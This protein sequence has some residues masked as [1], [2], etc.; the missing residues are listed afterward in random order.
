MILTILIILG[1]AFYIMTPDER[2]RA[3]HGGVE[4]V[5]KALEITQRHYR[6]R[7]AFR[8]ALGDRTPRVLVTPAFGLLNVLVFVLMMTSAG[9]VGS[10]ETLAAWGGNLGLQTTNG[11]WWRLVTNVFLHRGLFHLVVN[12]IGLVQ[13]GLVLERLVGRLAFAGVYLAGGSLASLVS[14]SS[15]PVDVSVGAS[16]AIFGLYGMFAVLLGRGWM[17]PSALSI[18][19][20][21]L[22]WLAPGATIFVL[23]N[24]VGG[25]L[26]GNQ[27]VGIFVGAVGGF[28]LVGGA[29]DQRPTAR[30]VATAMAA[31]IILAVAFAVPLRSVED[32][33]PEIETILDFEVRTASTY[34][35]AV[36][37]FRRGRLTSDDLVRLINDTIV[38][39][40][41]NYQTRLEAFDRVPSEHE[42]LVSS[43]VEYLELR[44]ESWRLRVQGLVDVD[45]RTLG[46]ADR[47]QRAALDVF[48]AL[49]LSAESSR[50]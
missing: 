8:D 5:R 14:L 44:D 36:N 15:H 46:E 9:P 30:R 32:V 47:Q 4:L 2:K 31:T 1:V 41:R 16:A 23:Y 26:G 24:L 13:I 20:T 50:R 48:E 25:G 35:E 6:A 42:L 33:R 38:P 29:G 21:T 45:M 19:L 27:M 34:Q 3:L 17:H 18:P 43:A 28:A 22:K 39:E 12:V 10:P 40:L 37:D 7:D 11:E 49:Q